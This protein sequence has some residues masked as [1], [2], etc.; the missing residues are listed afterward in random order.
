[1]A[2]GSRSAPT[3]A[4]PPI[5]RRHVAGAILAVVL[6]AIAA[7]ALLFFALNDLLV[8]RMWF[9]SLGQLAVWDLNTF[10]RLLLWIPVTLV[11]FL[12]LTA[13]VWIAVRLGGGGIAAPRIVAPGQR[14]AAAVPT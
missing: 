2:Q 1:M 11:A 7:L 6:I 8:D 5:T 3:G 10:S 4:R 13:S 12:V 14:S 9:E